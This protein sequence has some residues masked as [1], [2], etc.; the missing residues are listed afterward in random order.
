MVGE[1]EQIPLYVSGDILEVQGG[2][3]WVQRA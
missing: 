1:V 2:P 3:K